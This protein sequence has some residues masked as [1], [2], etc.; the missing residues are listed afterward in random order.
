[1]RAIRP[2]PGNRGPLPGPSPASLDN[3][4]AGADDGDWWVGA[5]RCFAGI[6]IAG[7][8]AALSV[9]SAIAGGF[10]ANDDFV[11]PAAAPLTS[12]AASLPSQRA[13]VE[14]RWQ[15]WFQGDELP[16]PSAAPALDEGHWQPP[17]PPPPLA[18]APAFTADDELGAPPAALVDAADPWLVVTPAAPAAVLRVFSADD[19]IA[20]SSTPLPL[21]EQYW[22]APPV[23]LVPP[24][25]GIWQQDEERPTPAAFTA[26]EDDAFNTLA[27]PA[28]ANVIVFATDEEIV[29]QAA[30]PA[31]GSGIPF[32]GQRARSDTRW[33][34]WAAPDEL[35]PQAAV[36]ALDDGAWLPPAPA[37]PAPIAR[38]WQAD[39][40]LPASTTPALDD[41]AG[42][43]AQA[44][45]PRLQL[46]DPWADEQP[47]FWPLDE[48]YA[49]QAQWVPATVAAPAFRA[50]D[51]IA[52]VAAPIVEDE[53]WLYLRPFAVPPAQPAFS[54]D[55]EVQQAVAP[56]PI[57]EQYWQ[58]PR[59]EPVPAVAPLFNAQDELPAPA[60]P[61][62]DDE[63]WQPPL[64]LPAAPRWTLWQV[65]D[66]QPTPAVLDETHLWP[67][68]PAAPVANTWQA[69]VD[70]D[71]APPPPVAVPDEAYW[72]LFASQPR[73]LVPAPVATLFSALD[74]RPFPPPP[75]PEEDLW[76][77]L[78][79]IPVPA[80]VRIWHE[81]DEVPTAPV[82]VPGWRTEGLFQA[83]ERLAQTS[84]SQRLNTS[85]STRK[86]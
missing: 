79:S 74:E 69:A 31:G 56:L 12:E 36:P 3:S 55:D 64:P 59:I 26:S 54:A 17:T 71:F 1:M 85:G 38:A 61:V 51:E 7:A 84:A 11:A 47:L 48:A 23:R 44:P 9:S 21:D 73:P 70:V 58:A 80:T 41:G 34:R 19:E 27:P 37:A 66:E 29:P 14:T 33:Q 22:Q 76:L 62:I 67:L 49:W 78:Y 81:Q 86:N 30:T 57:E 40:D 65:E 46:P 43:A 52:S 42:W 4:I 25:F 8:A 2:G 83:G 6:A 16:T 60:A 35:P 75:M 72:P 10:N 82:V 45:A 13:R 39:D 63:A 50:D 68:P 18:A 28:S 77:R 5:Q 53:A 15:Q 32:Y 20:Q 24:L